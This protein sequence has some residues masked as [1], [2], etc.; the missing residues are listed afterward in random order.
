M[1]DLVRHLIR[2][3]GRLGPLPRRVDE[4][5]GAVVPD[6]LD[7]LERLPEVVLGLAWETDD[8]VGTERET[9][10]R[11]AQLGDEPQVALGGRTCAA[12]P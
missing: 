8:D 11:V 10:D 3:R 2:Q 5:E 7:H 1:L 6:L 12:S 4:R 9:R